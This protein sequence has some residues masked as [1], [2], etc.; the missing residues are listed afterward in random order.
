VT[1]S[2]DPRAAAL[3][4]GASSG[5]G[6]ELVELFAA[7]GHELVLVA[8]RAQKLRQIADDIGE[9]Y[10]LQAHV[11][12]A[13]LADPE[14]PAQLASEV[15]RLGLVVTHLVNNAGFATSGPFAT[16]DPTTQRDMIQVNVT[17]LTSLTR[18][19]LP[20][21]VDRGHGRI[22]NVA[23]TAAFQPGPLMAVYYA[24]KAY[25]LNLSIA[26]AVELEGTGVTVTTL[27][28]GPTRT[29]FAEEAG[30]TSSTLFDRG[31]GMAADR[32]A[33]EGY[34][35]MRRGRP[36]IVSGKL[37]KTLAFATR[38]TPRSLGA[39]VVQRLHREEH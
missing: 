1:N 19:F 2:D 34:E 28:P 9:R 31:R 8:R 14:A 10:D 13:D 4:T 22:L 29:G 32:V 15:G 38:L 18:C 23:S 39:R 5:I 30:M 7:D 36:I 3:I 21:M 26:L 17:A 35:A 11:L 24:T 16:A 33:R 12:P 27:C 37:N 6:L 25:V 20:Q